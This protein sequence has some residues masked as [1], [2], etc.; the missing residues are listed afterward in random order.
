MGQNILS[1]TEILAV[2]WSSPLIIYFSTIMDDGLERDG[3]LIQK[4]VKFSGYLDKHAH[5][6]LIQLSL[7]FKTSKRNSV[8]KFKKFFTESQCF[9]L[10]ST[11]KKMEEN[12]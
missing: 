5:I 12:Y 8:F 3:E 6:I 7:K 2:H 1:N 9:F 10:F 4:Q 11:V